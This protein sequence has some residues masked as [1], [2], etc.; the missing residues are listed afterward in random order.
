MFGAENQIGVET[1]TV[2]F[3]AQNILERYFQN[4][5]DQKISISLLKGG[6]S[7]ATIYRV[8]Y[9]DKDYVL[10]LYQ[11]DRP[12]AE[13]QKE[14]FALLEGSNLGLAPKIYGIFWDEKAILMD[15]VKEKTLSIGQIKNPDLIEKMAQAIQK[16]HAMENPYL[17]YDLKTKVNWF[18]GELTKRFGNKAIF[19][20]A[21]QLFQLSSEELMRK[22][23]PKVTIHGD[24]N[25]NNI[26]F[27]EEGIKFIDWPETMRDDPFFDLTWFSLLN[28]LTEEEERYFLES[29][30]KRLPTFE[31]DERFIIVKKMNLAN[32][33]L[34]CLHI[35]HRLSYEL[36]EQALNFEAIPKDWDYYI[37]LFANNGKKLSAQFF[38]GF[39]EAALEYA[40][41]IELAK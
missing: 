9:L 19:N 35:A 25:P 38:L 15:F 39:A 29:Y 41:N 13:V 36:P 31:E 24:L 23:A 34:T 16:V 4:P 12:F 32:L 22:E 17:T 20:E 1:D 14:F 8:K 27:T 37:G 3:K 5:V 40:K 26:F 10:R 28:G 2:L 18:H 6:Y 21:T 30:F 7:S 33:C 11:D